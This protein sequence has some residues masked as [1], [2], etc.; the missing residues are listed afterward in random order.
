MSI[1]FTQVPDNFDL[2][3][4]I[5]T[6]HAGLF[7]TGLTAHHYDIVCQ[8]FEAS[9]KNLQIDPIAIEQ[10]KSVVLP[11]REIFAQGET[12]SVERDDKR[13]RK[14]G[15]VALLATSI[16]AVA[17]YRWFKSRRHYG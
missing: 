13:K 1:A 14:Q 6:K 12:N 3:R 9:L 7:D 2:K 15:I 11:L 4:L 5:L 17:V 16:V 8:H 10:A